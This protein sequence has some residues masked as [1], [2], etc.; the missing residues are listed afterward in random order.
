MV[1]IDIRVGPWVMVAGWLLM[2]L[3][4]DAIS[5]FFAVVAQH[6]YVHRGKARINGEA[7]DLSDTVLLAITAAMI[8]LAQVV[9]AG[10]AWEWLGKAIGK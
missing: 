8:A 10:I 9:P 4:V 7:W 5:L 3:F 6:S 1:W 2:M